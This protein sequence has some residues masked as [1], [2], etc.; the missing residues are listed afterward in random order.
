MG[1]NPEPF[2]TMTGYVVKLLMSSRRSS[3]WLRFHPLEIG[4]QLGLIVLAVALI[5]ILL[6]I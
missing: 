4:L 3:R 5:G 2:V 6:S 1:V